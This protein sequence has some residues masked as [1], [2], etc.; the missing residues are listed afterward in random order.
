MSVLLVL[1]LLLL[2]LP[3]SAIVQALI[4][5]FVV[6]SLSDVEVGFV[7]AVLTVLIAGFVQSAASAALFGAD[8]GCFGTFVG[9]V[10]WSGAVAFLHELTLARAMVV[11]AVMSALQWFMVLAV[12]GLGVAGFLGA[13]FV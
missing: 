9:F 2:V 12:I 4:F 6:R 13:L 7:S 5:R 10:V 1:V 3:L 8:G 11:G